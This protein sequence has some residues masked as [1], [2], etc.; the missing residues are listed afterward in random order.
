MRIHPVQVLLVGAAILIPTASAGSSPSSVRQDLPAQI[1]DLRLVDHFGRDDGL[2]D[3]RGRVVVAM[4]VTARRLRNLKAWETNLRARYDGLDF[5]RIADVPPDPP[6]TH[7]QVAQKF[8][9]RVPEEVPIL[10]DLAGHW[11]R[12][13]E[14]DTSRPNVL[15][16]DREGRLAGSFRERW[17][18][19]PVDEV[20][21]LL[22]ELTGRP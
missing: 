13:L 9:R 1:A 11:A 6:V 2:T 17:E 8:A 22:D 12:E 21:A 4:V 19:A 16:F 15:L 7:E 14:L 5:L 18:E 3:H 10:I 20:Y